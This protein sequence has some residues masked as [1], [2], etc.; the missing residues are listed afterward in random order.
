MIATPPTGPLRAGG[1]RPRRRGP[2]RGRTPR[3]SATAVAGCPRA[4]GTT[5]RCW[6]G[7]A[8]RAM[9]F[10]PSRAASATTPPSTPSRA[11]LAAGAD[12]LL[13]V[14]LALHRAGS[15]VDRRRERESSPS[16]PPSWARWPATSRAR[17]WSSAWWRCCTRRR[18]RAPI[19]WSSPS[20]RSRR[21]SPAGTIDDQ[22]ELDAWFE[23][24]MPSPETAAAVRRGARGW[25]R[26]LPG[27][28]R[29]DARGPPLQHRGAG[30]TARAAGRR[31]PQ[32]PPA[33]ATPSTSRGGAS[34]TS[35]SATSRSATWASARV[36]AVG[37]GHRRDDDLQRPALARDLPRAGP[38][39]RRADHV[40]YNTPCHN[41]P[42][43]EHDALRR[44]PQPP[45][46]AVRRLPERHA[47]WSGWPRRATR[48]AC[49]MI[50]GSAHRGAVGRDRRPLHDGRRRGGG[51]PLRPR[52][53]A[54]PTPAR[55]S[56][57]ACTARSRRTG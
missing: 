25:H 43:P 57:S 19:S 34:S 28:R 10:A 56:T 16:P 17:R 5:P 31:V 33:R 55:R 29:A 22:A 45:R 20:W 13:H 46:D 15:T 2:G 12:V 50:G 23:R 44:L 49:A 51:G 26:L 11:D 35:R 41:P 4:P 32:D 3:A 37:G 9:I 27:L 6:P 8:R 52:T 38:A 53:A 1:L 40:G 24:E 7:C 18:R 30:A 36:R 14:L 47:G 42:A 21:S 39:G 54:P 48:R